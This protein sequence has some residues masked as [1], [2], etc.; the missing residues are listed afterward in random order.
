MFP[1]AGTWASAIATCGAGDCAAVA[2][3]D[4]VVVLLEAELVVPVL[5]PEPEVELDPEPE[6]VFPPSLPDAGAG[7]SNAGGDR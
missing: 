1:A 7:A 3:D 6:L 4:E 5:L 2:L